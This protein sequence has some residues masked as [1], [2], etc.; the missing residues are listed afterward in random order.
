[1][2]R[3][4]V[5]R[6]V[7]ALA[8]IA[9]IAGAAYLAFNTGA[10][11]G[12]A[13]SGNLPELTDLPPRWMAYHHYGFFGFP[14]LRCLSVLAIFFLIAVFLRGL[15]GWHHPHSWRGHYGPCGEGVPPFIE[16]WH[17]RMHETKNSKE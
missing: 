13:Q 1:M 2:N 17:R 12:L 4:I 11:Y 15:C 5:W 7:V 3:T 10:A 8:V 9:G 14:G 16:E 6:I